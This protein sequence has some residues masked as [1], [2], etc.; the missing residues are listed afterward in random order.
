MKSFNLVVDA[1]NMLFR[2]VFSP[3]LVRKSNKTTTD[4]T[5]HF[6]KLLRSYV[7]KFEP[8]NIYICWDKRL[9]ATGN[10]FRKIMNENYKAHRETSPEKELAIQ[11]VE[12]ITPILEAAGLKNLYPFNMEADD[13][14]YY[15][16]ETLEGETVIISSD[17][18]L[19]QCIN[20]HTYVYNAYSK[21]LLNEENFRSNFGVDI[22]KWALFLAVKGDTSDNIPGLKGYGKVRSTNLVNDFSNT[23]NN[24]NTEQLNTIKSNLKLI[25]LS[26]MKDNEEVECYH[27][28]METAPKL[29]I[30]KFEEMCNHYGIFEKELNIWKRILLEKEMMN[31]I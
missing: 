10:N 17:K 15:L 26:M 27:S 24:L 2:T 8:N 31:L 4:V 16:S 3:Y 11:S 1:N 18:D 7:E 22:N 14:I 5:Y 28:Q 29:D 13:I 23:H 19:Y 12:I 25:D 9:N 21:K 20:N 6:M 30:V